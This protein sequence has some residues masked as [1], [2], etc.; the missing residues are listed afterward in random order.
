MLNDLMALP[1]QDRRLHAL[2]VR[3]TALLATAVV[4]LDRSE[5]TESA[6]FHIADDSEWQLTILSISIS[7]SCVPDTCGQTIAKSSLTLVFVMST[8]LSADIRISQT[9]RLYTCSQYD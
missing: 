3:I 4:V 8:A 7:L 2:H 5:R 6:A 9:T 1:F